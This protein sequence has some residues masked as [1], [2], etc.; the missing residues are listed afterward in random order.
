[1]NYEMGLNPQYRGYKKEYII[2][3]KV[4]IISDCHFGHR[5]ICKYRTQFSSIEEHN[6]FILDNI[7]STVT[8]RD[9]L[10]ML[11][12][13]FFT[14]EAIYQYGQAIS[15]KIRHTCVILGNHDTDNTERALN[16]GVMWGMFTSIH[17]LKSHRGCWLSHAPIHENELRGKI[18]IHGHVHNQTIKDDRYFNACCENINYTPV[19]QED[20]LNGYRGE[21]FT[22]DNTT[23]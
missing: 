11:G 14:R 5:N 2:M 22:N 16:V 21:L 7:L 3:G 23:T 4:Y 10:Y 12:D 20:I 18:N 13:M 8:K 17:G 6:E 15:D 19:L 1:M 9:V